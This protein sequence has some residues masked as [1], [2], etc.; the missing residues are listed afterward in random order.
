MGDTLEEKIFKTHKE[1][2]KRF[3]ERCLGIS[4]K[5]LDKKECCIVSQDHYKFG[6]PGKTREEAFLEAAKWVLSGV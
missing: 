6:V 3:D 5:T 1:I 4:F 2:K